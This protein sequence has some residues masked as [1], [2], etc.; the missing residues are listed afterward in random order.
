[1]QTAEIYAG[2]EYLGTTA[3]ALCCPNTEI[4]RRRLGMAGA[5]LGGVQISTLADIGCGFADLAGFLK[6]EVIYIG[7]DS[8][9]AFIE[10]ARE[11]HPELFLIAQ[12]GIEWLEK[13]EPQSMDAVVALGVLATCDSGQM[14]ELLCLMRRAARKIVVVSWQ[15]RREYKGSFN[16]WDREDVECWLGRCKALSSSL[17]DTEYTGAFI[18]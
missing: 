2:R 12:N 18:P 14:R 15:E 13:C 8:T 9:P 16:A 5:L 4:H 10:Q 11:R 17:N 1:M 7:V 6:P 3:Q